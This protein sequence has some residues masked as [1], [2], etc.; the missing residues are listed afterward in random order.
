MHQRDPP[1][2]NATASDG[3]SE[4][5]I[6]VTWNDVSGESSYEVWRNTSNDPG[7]ATYLATK[8]ANVTTHTDASATPGQ[9]YYYWIKAA[10]CAGDS[11]FGSGDYGYRKLSTVDNVIASYNAFTNR[12]EIEWSDV[13]GETGYGIYRYTSDNSGSA[14]HIGTRSRGN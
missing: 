13:Q 1:A 12:V 11:A 8:A 2:P 9:R 14:S 5:H 7:T 6:T 3:A 4:L 10:N